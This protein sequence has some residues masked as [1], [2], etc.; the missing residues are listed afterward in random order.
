M[1]FI[2]LVLPPDLDEKVRQYKLKANERWG[3]RVGLKSPAHITFVSP[4]WLPAE[5]EGQLLADLNSAVIEVA[6]F[7]VR[8]ANISSFPPRT[9]FIA[10]AP[11]AALEFLKMQ[12]DNHFSTVAYKIKKEVRPFHPHITIATRDWQEK[13]FWEAWEQWK[14]VLFEET[15]TAENLSLL[16]H[17]GSSWDVIAN[18]DFATNNNDELYV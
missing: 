5:Q 1:Y 17:N 13:D 11:N 9:L 14:E 3:C 18:A 6:P 4:F 7:E 12:V 10:V 15:F 2:A 8:T 16:R